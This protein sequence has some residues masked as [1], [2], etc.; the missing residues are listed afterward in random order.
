MMNTLKAIVIEVT[1]NPGYTSVRFQLVN[2]DG[3]ITSGDAFSICALPD[4]TYQVGQEFMVK[5]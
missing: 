3:V 1:E 2:T 4:S 5:L